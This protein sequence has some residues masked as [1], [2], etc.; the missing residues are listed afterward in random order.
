MAKFEFLDKAGAQAIVDN[1]K[2]A[3]NTK[4]DKAALENNVKYLDF[5]H[6]GVNRKTIQLANYDSISGIDT[7]GN[8]HNLV[9]LSKW[10][11]ADFGATGVALNL[12]GKNE[13]PTYNDDKELALVSDIDSK[14]AGYVKTSDVEATVATEVGKVIN[15]A[16]ET[17]DTLKEIADW[18]ENHTDASELIND[19]ADKTYVDEVKETLEDTIE[20]NKAEV[21]AVLESK[22][23]KGNYLE[24]TKDENGRKTIKLGNSDIF[25]AV[26]NTEVIPDQVEGVTGWVS[27]MQLNKWNVCDFGSDKTLFNINIKRGMRPTIQETGVPGP[28]AHQMAYLSDIPEVTAISIEEIERMFA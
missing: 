28:Q 3:L 4:A 10:D 12:N 6:N 7:K 17:F 5:I 8:G 16:P 26:A 18:I 21:E 24:Y 22:Q 2:V 23:D 15:G 13:R 20:S 14:L 19:K 27:L 25:G 9:M 11:I 1:V